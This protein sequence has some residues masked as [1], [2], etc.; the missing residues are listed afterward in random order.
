[1]EPG[2]GAVPIAASPFAFP[3]AIGDTTHFDGGSEQSVKLSTWV[4][5]I[6]N[7]QVSRVE[8]QQFWVFYPKFWECL[9]K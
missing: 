3:P 2:P 8:I 9:P 6:K 1:M 5:N 4:A 7:Q